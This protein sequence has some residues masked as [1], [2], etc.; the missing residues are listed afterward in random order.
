MAKAK[1][2][3]TLQFNCAHKQV[4]ESRPNPRKVWPDP[5][6]CVECKRKRPIIHIHYKVVK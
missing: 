1:P 3:I 2:I 5:Q 6:M 4:V